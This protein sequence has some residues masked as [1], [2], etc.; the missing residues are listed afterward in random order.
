MEVDASINIGI[1][2]DDIVKAI[3][4]K[5]EKIVWR[6]IKDEVGDMDSAIE[7]WMDNTSIEDYIDWDSAARSGQMTFN[8]T[9]D[10]VRSLI[11]EVIE[12]NPDVLRAII[13]QQVQAA[14][15]GYIQRIVRSEITKW[16]QS[17]GNVLANMTHDNNKGEYQ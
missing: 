10:E 8:H 4:P 6:L 16:G 3:K 11:R 12:L 13:A 5:L 15:D 2:D 7:S 9:D 17:F 14:L 1:N